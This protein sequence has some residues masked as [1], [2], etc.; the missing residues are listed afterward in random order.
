MS[1]LNFEMQNVKFWKIFSGI[2]HS[3]IFA[4]PKK[5]TQ[6]KYAK[7]GQMLVLDCLNF[8]AK[9]IYLFIFVSDFGIEL[10]EIRMNFLRK[11]CLK[12]LEFIICPILQ[13]VASRPEVKTNYRKHSEEF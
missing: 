10:T 1:E 7:Y 13:Q 5:R 8:S 12:L 3:T 6:A 2:L 4:A 11:K 9:A